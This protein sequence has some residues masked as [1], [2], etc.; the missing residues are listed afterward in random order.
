MTKAQVR[1]GSKLVTRRLG[2]WFLKPGDLLMAI[3]KGQGLKK[4]EKVVRIRPIRVVSSKG[5]VLKK[6]TKRDVRLE[7]FPHLTPRLFVM[8]FCA[9][10][11]CTPEKVVNRIRFE[12]I[13]LCTCC[14]GEGR[15][16]FGENPNYSGHKTTCPKCFGSGVDPEIE[17]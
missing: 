14:G 11:A 15:G 17:L 3:E 10:H 9:G 12:Y 8:M 4:G 7:G 13:T 5:Q 1:E 6:I 16:Y 2:W